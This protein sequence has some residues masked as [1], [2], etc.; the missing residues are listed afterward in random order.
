[1]E[2]DRW[3]PALEP[4]AKWFDASGGAEVVLGLRVDRGGGVTLAS[5]G[6]GALAQC[7]AGGRARAAAGGAERLYWCR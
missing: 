7:A 1:M 3:L 5:A 2:L 6:P 4:C